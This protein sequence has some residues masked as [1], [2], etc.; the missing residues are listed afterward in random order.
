[1]YLLL[2]PRQ[3]RDARSTTRASRTFASRRDRSTEC[4]VAASYYENI[5]TTDH[6]RIL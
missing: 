5:R 6:R 1:M 4:G 2:P 3:S